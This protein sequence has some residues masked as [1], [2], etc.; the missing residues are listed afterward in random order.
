MNN[1]LSSDFDIIEMDDWQDEVV[2]LDIEFGAFS[3]ADNNRFFSKPNNNS[4]ISSPQ[5]SESE[6]LTR[7]VIQKVSARVF[8]LVR[9][10]KEKV[11]D[12]M[13]EQEAWS[14][15]WNVNGKNTATQIAEILKAP[16]LEVVYQIESLRLLG[17]V[18][19]V[20]SISLPTFIK[21]KGKKADNVPS[22]NAAVEPSSSKSTPAIPKPVLVKPIIE[23]KNDTPKPAVSAPVAIADSRPLDERTVE[24]EI[25]SGN[26]P[27]GFQLQ[28]LIR[29]VYARKGSGHDAKMS[30]YLMMASINRELLLQEGLTSFRYFDEDIYIQNPLLVKELLHQA[31]RVVGYD[32]RHDLKQDVGI[33]TAARE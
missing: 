7:L 6:E 2:E 5:S 23:D 16:L 30:V 4:V 26:A 25:L 22:V 3:A 1:I 11:K 33:Y 9:G 17:L 21:T 29:A 28:E 10:A 19:P 27:R 18:C 15:L 8:R 24:V 32:I 13:L 20:D 12:L 14:I 31:S